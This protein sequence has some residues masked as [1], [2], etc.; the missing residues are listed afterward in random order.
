MMEPEMM[1]APAMREAELAPHWLG[2][3]AEAAECARQGRAMDAIA[4]YEEILKAEPRC[5]PAYLQ[6]GQ[7][8]AKH[9]Q[10][11]AAHH[12]LAQ[13]VLNSPQDL[14]LR[15]MLVQV[16]LDGNA[17]DQAEAQVNVVMQ[18]QPETPDAHGLLARV[19]RYQGRL[20]EAQDCAR[21]CLELALLVPLKTNAQS[22]Q[23][24]T[25]KSNGFA[26]GAHEAMLWRTL[27]QLRE[28]KVQAVPTSGTLL[29]LVREGRLLPFDKDTDIALPFS[30]MP[31]AIACLQ[32]RGWKEFRRSYGLSNPRA[33]RHVESGMVMDLCG[34]MPARNGEGL[35]GGFWMKGLPDDWQRYTRCPVVPL[36]DRETEF[37][38]VWWLSK[39]ET[40]L[41]AL[42]GPDWRIPDPL[43]D[44]VVA[45]YNLVGF[46]PMTQFYAFSRIYALGWVNGRTDKA[47]ATVRH[48]LR[49]L[50]GDPLLMRTQ[51]VLEAASHRAAH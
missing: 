31:A 23:P 22:G 5:T 13:G 19:R 12:V 39:P 30:Q 32:A 9:E 10:L 4:R 46:S 1:V 33:F 38:K 35:W 25:G 45:A 37:G 14:D 7:L 44:T 43:F 29:G 2:Q 49:Q 21:K 36:T 16:L 40:W 28:A 20:P 47:L 8:L 51:R 27:A 15:S 41:E 26:S 11:R 3:L 17:L 34:V 24:E 50:P 6:L 42:Y 48:A 18:R